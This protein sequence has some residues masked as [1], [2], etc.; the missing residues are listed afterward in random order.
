[1]SGNGNGASRVAT[2]ASG[3]TFLLDD[4]ALEA[5]SP[6]GVVTRIPKADLGEGL[7]RL[8]AIK[9]AIIQTKKEPEARTPATVEEVAKARVVV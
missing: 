8:G 3:W 5:T 1:M 2:T 9:A 7:T 4:Q 6:D